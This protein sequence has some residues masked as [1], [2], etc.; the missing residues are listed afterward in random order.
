MANQP[1]NRPFS[2]SSVGG[3]EPVGLSQTAPSQQEK[4]MSARNRLLRA[5]ELVKAKQYL[6]AGEL[7]KPILKKKKPDPGAFHLMAVIC[8]Q[9]NQHAGALEYAKKAHNAVPNN[10]TK[11][12]IARS[13]RLMGNTEECVRWADKILKV[14][15]DNPII[16]SI[17]AGALEDA[18]RVDEAEA[19]LLPL[20]ERVDHDLS[21]LPVPVRDIWAR[22]LVQRKEYPK[23]I[24]IIDD[25]L[26]HVTAMQNRVGVLHLKAKACDRSKQYDRAWEAAVLA[27]EPGRLEYDPDLHTQQVDAL[28]DI[29][30]KEHTADFPITTCESIVPVFV[31]GMPR[32]GTSLIDQI[33]DAHPNAAGVGELSAIETFAIQLSKN[34]DPEEPIENRFGET[35][36]KSW[37]KTADSYISH[38]LSTSPKGTERV[39]NKALGNNK[40]VGLIARLFPKT[41]IIHAIRDP[42]DVAISCFMGGFNNKMHPWTSKV[43]WAAHTWMLSERMMNHWKSTLDVPILDVHYENLVA[44]PQHEFPRLIEF[45]GLDFDPSCYDFHKS[46]RTVRTL[47]YDQVNRPLYTT[48]SGRHVNYEKHIRDIE[49]PRYEPHSTGE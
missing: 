40:L 38:I 22:V 16:T 41:R 20:I 4:G 43:E 19:V 48:S 1:P 26:E 39:V 29:W 33:I 9:L 8:E 11:M 3:V 28:I 23:A 49:F 14:D 21:K 17:K 36:L 27:N 15:P 10:Q 42:K 5:H 45:L 35:G 37:Q 46:N 18:G 7:L 13:N 44:N 34:Y 32:S 30:S 2:L 25:V 12:I 6:Q 24:E 31:A 47:S